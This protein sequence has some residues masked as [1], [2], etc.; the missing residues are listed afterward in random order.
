MAKFEKALFDFH[1]GYL[2]YNTPE[3]ERKFVARF[4]HVKGDRAGFTKFLIKNFS[5]EE[6]F[7]ALEVE[8]K[9][10]LPILEAKGYVMAHIKK[11]LRDAGLP[12]TQE[13][14]KMLLEQRI[15]VRV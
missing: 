6:Y 13:G 12:E 1:G 11:W 9:S 5:V 15:A 7:N 2:H 4:K 14:Q 8:K 3:G 10:P